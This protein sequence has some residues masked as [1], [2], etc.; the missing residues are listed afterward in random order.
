MQGA[1]DFDEPAQEIVQFPASVAAALRA[2]FGALPQ[3]A[4]ALREANTDGRYDDL[5]TLC[6][7]TAVLGLRTVQLGPD[8]DFEEYNSV[9][10]AIYEPFSRAIT[11]QPQQHR[12]LA[13]KLT[14]TPDSPLSE[15]DSSEPETES[16]DE[17]ASGCVVH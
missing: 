8:L 15:A 6:G 10:S 9:Y 2:T 4:T 1:E 3:C 14:P 11:C 16:D 12:E 5:L 7:T 17:P 13:Q